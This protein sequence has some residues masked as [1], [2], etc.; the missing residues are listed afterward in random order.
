MVVALC[1]ERWKG[2]P[3]LPRAIL[4]P[5]AW[6]PT[7]SL[8]PLTAAPHPCGSRGRLKISASQYCGY[9]NEM[10]ISKLACILPCMLGHDDELT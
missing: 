4:V 5:L 7:A 2:Y 6:L 9:G 8:A 1:N 10:K 3:A